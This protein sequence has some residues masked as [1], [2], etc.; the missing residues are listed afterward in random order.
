MDADASCDGITWIEKWKV[1]PFS[2][3]TVD[4]VLYSTLAGDVR[5]GAQV[6]VGAGL[7][8]RKLSGRSG[9]CDASA[10]AQMGSCH[11][12]Q[13]HF[14]R[15]AF[16]EPRIPK[17]KRSQKLWLSTWIFQKFVIKCTKHSHRT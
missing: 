12:G 3:I 15:L 8:T 17:R 1:S 16:L 10:K 7:C 14:V 5:G 2:W 6:Q 11:K 9:G 4:S 13:V